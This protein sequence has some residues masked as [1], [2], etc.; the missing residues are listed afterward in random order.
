LP[1]AYATI[2]DDTTSTGTRYPL[3]ANQTS[4]NVATEYTSSTKL[5][6]QP[7]TG[8]LTATVFS[9]SLAASNLTGTTLPSTIVTSSLTTVGTIGTGIWQGTIV[10]TTYGGTGTSYGVNGGT[11]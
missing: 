9:G 10:A 8:T 11:F 7:S 1:T 3:F 2:T 6:Y 5:Q 4:G